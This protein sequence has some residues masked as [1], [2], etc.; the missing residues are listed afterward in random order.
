MQCMLLLLSTRALTDLE[1]HSKGLNEPSL[2]K[3]SHC[4]RQL[5][6]NEIRPILRKTWEDVTPSVEN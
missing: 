2:Q 5:I 1:D 6:E 3:Q 4:Q